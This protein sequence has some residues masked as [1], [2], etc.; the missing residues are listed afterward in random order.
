MHMP[1]DSIQRA[2]TRAISIAAAPCIVLDLVAD[3][4]NLPR[5]A[6][7]FARAVRRDGEDWLI[8]QG[9]TEAR[10]T[11]RVSRDA[12]TVD[13]LAATDHRRGAFTR[14]VPN[15]S[16]SEYVFTLFFPTDAEEIT[17]SG[18]MAVVEE[19]LQSVRTLCET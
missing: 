3:P 17:V 13:L 9:E 10:I 1:T 19:E 15:G 11:V 5:W 4:R 14:V 16:G 18:Q 8:D 7:K 2:E 12:G 6:P